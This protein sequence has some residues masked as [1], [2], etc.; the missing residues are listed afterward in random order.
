MNLLILSGSL[1]KDPERKTFQSGSLVNFTLAETI[2]VNGEKKAVWHDCSA[3]GK[4]SDTI[5]RYCQKGTNVTVTGKLVYDEYTNKEG[6]NVKRAKM[7]VFSVE[8][9]ARW[10][11]V[12]TVPGQQT[13]PTTQ[14]QQE[15]HWA[16]GSKDD[17]PF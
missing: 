5:E 15:G 6:Q 16:D 7:N 17:L 10:R 2:V 13:Q 14:A 8:I 12:G 1:G 11:E 9:N 4:T 3:F